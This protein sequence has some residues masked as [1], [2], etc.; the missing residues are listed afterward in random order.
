M[1]FSGEGSR[2]RSRV[3]GSEAEDLEL[4][5]YAAWKRQNPGPRNPTR[6]FPSCLQIRGREDHASSLVPSSPDQGF[7]RSEALTRGS[8]KPHFPPLGEHG[9]G[10][11]HGRHIQINALALTLKEAGK[12]P[13]LTK[14]SLSTSDSH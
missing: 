11:H 1:H 6:I 13:L 2:T 7:I 12:Q 4:G 3:R 14:E 10:R 8:S 5:D 9:R